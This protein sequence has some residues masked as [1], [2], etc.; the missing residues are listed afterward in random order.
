MGSY[1]GATCLP[2]PRAGASTSAY[3][4]DHGDRECSGADPIGCYS[5]KS[6]RATHPVDSKAP[7]PWGLSDMLGNVGEWGGATYQNYDGD[8]TDPLVL[9]ITVGSR[10][11]R[12]SACSDD[13]RP[14]R[15]AYRDV[16]SAEHRNAGV[17]LRPA[18]TAP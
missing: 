2:A 7:T 14:C 17:G 6:E 9:P 12:G 5:L 18:R 13:A 3:S 1:P 15:A 10:V 4:G 16:G 11:H 8:A